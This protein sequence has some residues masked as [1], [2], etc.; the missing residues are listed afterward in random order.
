MP[1]IIEKQDWEGYV[2]VKFRHPFYQAILNR[3]ADSYGAALRAFLALA[4]QPK[5]TVG[6][7]ITGEIQR[8][9]R[10]DGHTD[11]ARPALAIG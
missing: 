4:P 1:S 3:E 10:P 6:I 7:A 11:G 5:Q 2:K 8:A 9:V